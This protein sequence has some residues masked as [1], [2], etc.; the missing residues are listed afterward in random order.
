MACDDEKFSEHEEEKQPV[1]LLNVGGKP[2][3]MDK[4]TLARY[5]DCL[6][7]KMV[8][9]FPGLVKREKRL[10]IDRNPLA[11]PWILEIHR[12]ASYASRREP[13]GS[14]QGRRLQELCSFDV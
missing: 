14:M 11:F 6:L 2:F 13:N 1:V 10:F 4:Y 9:E 5:P 12:Q 8:D 3:T 7:A